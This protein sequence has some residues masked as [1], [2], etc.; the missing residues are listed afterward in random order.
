MEKDGKQKGKKTLHED[1]DSQ[2]ARGI[3][4]LVRGNTVQP[5]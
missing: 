5:L 2:E 1:S 4:C 3:T